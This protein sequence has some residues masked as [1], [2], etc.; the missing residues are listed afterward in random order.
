[1]RNGRGQ[2][3][4]ET[5]ACV[6]KRPEGYPAPVKRG[7]NDLVNRKQGEGEKRAAASIPLIRC[8]DRKRNVHSPTGKSQQG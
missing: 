2:L 6:E 3:G 7:G 1:M 5:I 8:K 4:T